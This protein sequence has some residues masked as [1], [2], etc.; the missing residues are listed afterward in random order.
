MT[1]SRVTASSKFI[2]ARATAVQVAHSTAS[3]FAPPGEFRRIQLLVRER[4]RCLTGEISQHG[5]FIRIR[6]ARQT[7]EKILAAF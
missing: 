2:T 7:L 6:L 4:W 5:Q 1:Y 3:A